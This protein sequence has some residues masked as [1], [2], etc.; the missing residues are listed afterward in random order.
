MVIELCKLLNEVK[1][2]TVTTENGEKT[3]LNNR[4]MIYQGKNKSTFVDITAWNSMAEFI[5]RN[6]KKDD[7]IYIEGELKNKPI[8]VGEQSLQTK[9]C[10]CNQCKAYIRK[11][12]T[13]NGSGG[14]IMKPIINIEAF[15]QYYEEAANCKTV[16]NANAENLSLDDE[17]RLDALLPIYDEHGRDM[18]KRLIVTAIRR[19]S[20]NYSEQVRKWAD[21]AIVAMFIYETD[22]VLSDYI[23]DH[24]SEAA[25]EAVAKDLIEREKQKNTVKSREG[26][27]YEVIKSEEANCL[28]CKHTGGIPTYCRAYITLQNAK[29][30]DFSDDWISEEV[31]SY[32]DMNKAYVDSIEENRTDK[33]VREKFDEEYINFKKAM[34]SKSPIDVFESCY[35][36]AAMEDVYCYVTESKIFT[37]EEKEYI[38]NSGDCVLTDLMQDWYDYGDW[39]DRVS[40]SVENTFSERMGEY[41]KSLNNSEDCEEELE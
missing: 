27:E 35:K 24:L 16:L 9:L 11:K 37:P 36:I 20:Q 30:M 23:P 14:L 41:Q 38:L 17:R 32:S 10:A 8:T 15:R 1:T 34:V 3:V 31:L 7:Q 25:I 21:N 18:V 6:F 22:N 5:E 13:E 40:D 2:K 28:L 33:L 12:R 4:V 26:T 19:D 29:D 39:N